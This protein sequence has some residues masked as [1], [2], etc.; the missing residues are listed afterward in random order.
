[1]RDGQMGTAEGP[2]A[3]PRY[4]RGAG[5]VPARVSPSDL[6]RAA[7]T[8]LSRYATSVA[9]L[10]QVLWR[11]VKRSAKAH[12]TDCEQAAAWIEALLERLTGLGYLDDRGFAQSQLRRLRRRGSSR[13]S[14]RAK[15][16]A[17]GIGAALIDELLREQ[18]E[19]AELGAA[20][21]YA[22]RRRLGPYRAQE[23]RRAAFRDKDLAA[24]AR[25]GF[26]RDV[27]ERVIDDTSR[28]DSDAQ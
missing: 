17:K 23:A 16:M 4:G 20:W 19:D 21:A 10:R 9:N 7:L 22:R 14:I 25:A 12:D 15:L 24:M 5:G 6:E 2:G 3:S 13:A 28:S 1:M 11:R 27:A 26:G 18:E 8:Y